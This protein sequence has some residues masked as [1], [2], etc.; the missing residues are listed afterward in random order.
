MRYRHILLIPLLLACCGK[1]ADAPAPA[2]AA[3]NDA[4][5]L[6]VDASPAADA[7]EDVSAA[8]A[9]TAEAQ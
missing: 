1:A 3:G 5:Q 9:A 2:P 6:P 4:A 7:A 8:D